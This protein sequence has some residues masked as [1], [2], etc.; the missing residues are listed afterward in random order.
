MSLPTYPV[1]ANAKGR[2]R[3][4]MILAIQVRIVTHIVP[5]GSVKEIGT[6]SAISIIILI[7]S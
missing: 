6:V 2:A 1:Y 5:P 4:I 3:A 7:S